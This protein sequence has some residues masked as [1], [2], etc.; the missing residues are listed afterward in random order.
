[1]DNFIFFEYNKWSGLLLPF[2]L[3]GML[4]FT[5][6]QIRGFKEAR[7]SDILLSG[8]ILVYTIEVGHWMLGFA[9]WYDAHNAYTTF[10]YYFPVD[11][12]FLLGPLVWFY[13]KSVTNRQFQF[14]SKDFW[15]FI[16]ELVYLCYRA[17]LFF[18][19][20]VIDHWISDRPLNYHYGTRGPLADGIEPF[21]GI[22]FYLGQIAVMVYFVATIRLYRRYRFYLNQ[23]FSKT[24]QVQFKWLRN[25]LYA[26][27]AGQLIALGYFLVDILSSQPLTYIDEWGAFFLWGVIIYYLSISGYNTDQAIFNKLDFRPSEAAASPEEVNSPFLEIKQRL[28]EF[29][30]KEKP[31]LDPELTLSEL[32][33][34]LSLPAPQIS[35]T[36]NQEMGQNFNELINSYRI[37]EVKAKMADPRNEHLSLLG[38]ALDSGF[39]SKATFNRVFKKMTGQ[40]PSEFYK[41]QSR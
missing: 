38:L 19:D 35:Q 8:I 15:H 26:V 5:L 25:F 1:L 24:D 30:E 41:K 12:S 10:I 27:V 17:G 34:Q 13:F 4:F 6:L 40:T 29:L 33:R 9:G 32:S 20:I 36:I 21:E 37:Q 11:H 39:N 7:W 18:K 3:Q 28:I 31:Y 23:N 16:P 14:Y 2:F 22:L